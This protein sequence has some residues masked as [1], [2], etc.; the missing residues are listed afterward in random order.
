MQNLPNP[1]SAEDLECSARESSKRK[2]GTRL[3]FRL[4]SNDGNSEPI[5]ETLSNVV[6]A[7]FAGR[8]ADATQHHIRELE[9]LGVTPPSSVPMFYRVSPTR[10]TQSP[11]VQMVGGQSS[12]EIECVL[13]NR[14][15]ELL[16]GIGSD[17]TDR[18][19]EAY[20]V[21]ESKQLC[22]KPIGTVLWRYD[23]VIEHWDE[24][25]MRCKVVVSEGGMNE[26]YQEGH[27]SG[28]I[29]P[30]ELI[31]LLEKQGDAFGAGSVMFC[32]TLGVK[33]GIRPA[34]AYDM[35]LHDP[36]LGRTL[37]HRY[38]VLEIPLRS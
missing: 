2:D 21:M 1:H 10:L 36:V 4:V 28:L 16:V 34:Q 11:L 37:K 13:I 15:G 22:D 35:E 23:E 26:I 29:H 17:H 25:I 7:G 19:L 12:G 27:V 38:E 30:K 24:L 3:D 9:E 31:A 6:I 14:D 20:G 33:G 32:G 5:S 8:D 18:K